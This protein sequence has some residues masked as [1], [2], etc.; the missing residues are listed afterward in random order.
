VV[1]IMMATLFWSAIV[2]VL[3]AAS[4]RKVAGPFNPLPT[5]QFGALRE[6]FNFGCFSWLQ[7][8]AGVTLS[9]ADRFIVGALLGTAPVAVYVICVQ[10]AQPIHGL[11]AAG[12]NF[13]FPH[14]S[15]RHEAGEAHGP[16]RVFMLALTT[17]VV[18]AGMLSLPFIL[19]ARPILRV[20]M[21]PQFAEQGHLALAILAVSYAALAINVVPHNSLLAL[22]RVR[23][24][25]ALN[26]AG[27]LVLLAIIAILIPRS[28]L[29]GAAAGRAIY[30]GL[31]AVGYLIA[32]RE[33]FLPK[34]ALPH[35]EAA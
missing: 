35:A 23:T 9:Y 19:L 7:A 16:R 26:V 5:L 10:A 24:V 31:L 30:T 8:L 32:C 13:L 6:V 29:A 21:G 18:V 34:I 11:T 3:Q 15:S 20:W 4:A 22:G 28:G 1:E 12:F 33:A 25:A 14:L 17:N 2:T 27:G